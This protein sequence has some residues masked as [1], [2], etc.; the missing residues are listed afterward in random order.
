MAGM[1]DVEAMLGIDIAG[2]AQSAQRMAEKSVELQERLA[3]LT[4]EAETPDGRVRVVFSPEEG[5]PEVHIDPR[6]MRMGSEELAATISRLSRE[7]VQDLQRR[8]QE[9]AGEV[10]GDDA[11]ADVPKPEALKETLRGMDDIV[12]AL[13]RDANA[14]LDQI[15][16]QMPRES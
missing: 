1:F 5:L 11:A 8:K 3:G 10:Y 7:A 16:R 12:Q 2:A 13:S 4:G 14:M 15:R 6:A 9:I